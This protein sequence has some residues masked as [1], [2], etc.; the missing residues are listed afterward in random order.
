M[1]LPLQKCALLPFNSSNYFAVHVCMMPLCCHDQA[2]LCVMIVN[3]CMLLLSFIIPSFGNSMF[4]DNI[5]W[6]FHA[7]R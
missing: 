7:P 6:Q 4:Q 1:P 5:L 3:C 2:C